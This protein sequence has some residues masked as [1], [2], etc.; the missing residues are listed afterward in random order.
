M[1]PYTPVSGDDL[2]GYFDLVI[3]VGFCSTHIY[4]YYTQV[5][6]ANEN[7]RFPAGGKMTQYLNGLPLGTPVNVQGPFGRLVYTGGGAFAI[8]ANKTDPPSSA[9]PVHGRRVGMVAGGSGITPMYQ[10]IIH[11][12]KHDTDTEMWLLYANQVRVCGAR[13]H[14]CADCG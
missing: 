4:F 7:A 8:R 10:F 5:Y 1:R 12:L 13:S 11:T 9:R 3:K 14:A 6:F 2:K